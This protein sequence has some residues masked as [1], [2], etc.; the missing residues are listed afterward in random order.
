[1]IKRRKCGPKRTVGQELAVKKRCMIGGHT[2]V[3]EKHRFSSTQDGLKKGQRK[4]G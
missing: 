3:D 4:K 1:M 2:I